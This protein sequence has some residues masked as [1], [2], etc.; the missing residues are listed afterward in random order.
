MGTPGLMRDQL[1][2]IPDMI[3][4][5]YR[6]AGGGGTG[7]AAYRSAVLA[8]APEFYYRFGGSSGTV[9]AD[10]MGTHAG[11]YVGTP[12]QAAAG[13]FAGNSAVSLNGSTQWITTPYEPTNGIPAISMECWFKSTDAENNDL[14]YGAI[15]SNRSAFSISLLSGVI[16]VSGRSD[17]SEG[18][19]SYTAPPTGLDDGGWHHIVGV[20]DYANDRMSAYIDGTPY[21][22]GAIG[23]LS[24]SLVSPVYTGNLNRVGSHSNV[25]N[26]ELLGDI[27]EF[28]LYE[29][30]LSPA[31]VAAHYNA[32]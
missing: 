13:I 12:N 2:E 21:T 18:F 29:F 19:K 9:A 16:R 23:F 15:G 26:R 17:E 4:N 10:E 24:A 7:E 5:P 11:T 31:R 20:L 14:F 8:D 32:R 22:S 28:A 6:F 30:A 1:F 3:I 27:D 25:T